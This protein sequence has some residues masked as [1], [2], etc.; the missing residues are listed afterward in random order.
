MLSAIALERIAYGLVLVTVFSLGL[1]ATLCALGLLF[2]YA[3]RG[4][5]DRR[6]PALWTRAVPVASALVITGVGLALCWEALDG[7][8][9]LTGPF[10][11]GG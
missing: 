8:K 4:L 5:R 6:L 1:A 11:L 3:G 7:V 9:S 10:W 2:V